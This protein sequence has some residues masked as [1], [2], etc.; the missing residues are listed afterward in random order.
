MTTPDRDREAARAL[1]EAD[2]IRFNREAHKNGRWD[3]AHFGMR[4]KGPAKPLPKPSRAWPL[5]KWSAALGVVACAGLFAADWLG[6]INVGIRDAISPSTATTALGAQQELAS[7]AIDKALGD[8][9]YDAPRVTDAPPVA[10][11]AG[12]FA[13]AD[14]EAMP[15]GAA[16]VRESAPQPL[17]RMVSSPAHAP[18]S[19]PTA[20]QIAERQ[21]GI[22][23]LSKQRTA[24]HAEV[25]RFL[26][27]IKRAETPGNDGL[28]YEQ[29]LIR[30]RKAAHESGAITSE[31]VRLDLAWE[32]YLDGKNENATRLA[33]AREVLASLD[34][35][36]ADARAALVP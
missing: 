31:R 27:V 33:H 10:T 13:P 4:A 36:I 34:K 8:S 17:A 11:P 26:A 15:E 21:R 14:P 30:D 3:E 35:R 23:H 1:E 28:T 16:P 12:P 25:D 19:A 20:A 5:V 2:R 6:A 7:A 32:N 22:A 18:A 24:A 29:R 9:P